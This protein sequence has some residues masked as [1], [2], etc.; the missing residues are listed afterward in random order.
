MSVIGIPLAVSGLSDPSV[1]YGLL[2]PMSMGTSSTVWLRAELESPFAASG[3]NGR[4][5]SG[6][7]NVRTGS[8]LPASYGFKGSGRV[9]LPGLLA[10]GQPFAFIGSKVLG[11][12]VS[13]PNS[14]SLIE[15]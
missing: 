7:V 2:F 6:K 8:A 9:V 4:E 3:S 12:I 1:S 14:P 10:P 13:P 11:S 15:R 5:I